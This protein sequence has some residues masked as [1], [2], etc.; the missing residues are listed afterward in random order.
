MRFLT[1]I[2]LGVFSMPLIATAADRD[3]DALVQADKDFAKATVV[4]GIDGWMQ[5]MAPNAVLL[6]AE[7]LV[8]VEQIRAGMNK[9][10]AA[11]GFSVTWA[12]VKADFVGDSDIGYTVGRYE[13]KFTSADGKAGVER[14]SYLTTWQKQKDGSWK[15]VSDIGSADPH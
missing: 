13:V 12:P 3:T 9:S 15:V 2:L 10:F 5:F 7:P 4:K 14:G 1:A 8:G 6:R 11:P